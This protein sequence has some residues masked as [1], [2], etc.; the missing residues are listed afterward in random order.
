MDGWL[1]YVSLVRARGLASCL[2]DF[3]EGMECVAAETRKM[4]ILIGCL[5]HCQGLSR[6]DVPREEQDG[7]IWQRG[8]REAEESETR[9]QHA[10]H[11]LNVCL[12]SP[13]C[14]K[15]RGRAGQDRRSEEG[16]SKLLSLFVTIVVIVVV[17][18]VVVVVIH[19]VLFV[20][21]YY[22]TFWTCQAEPAD[23]S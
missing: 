1:R 11:R 18:V 5:R 6:V 19:S 3:D 20:L 2:W 9:L 7:K 4:S 23:L 21:I 12:S 22:R 8:A 10:L 17:I 13:T 14:S 16:M 15:C